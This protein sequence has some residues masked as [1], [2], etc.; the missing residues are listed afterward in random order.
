MPLVYLFVLKYKC[1]H[2][3]LKYI[4]LLKYLGDS[5]KE[6]TN[7]REKRDLVD[8]INVTNDTLAESVQFVQETPTEAEAA[9]KQDVMTTKLV[10]N[11]HYL[12]TDDE[13]FDNEDGDDSENI[14]ESITE[15]HSENSN[16]NQ[17]P[18]VEKPGT[19][20]IKP[21]LKLYNA[22]ILINK[23]SLNLQ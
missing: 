3:C 16:D 21:S 15:F 19:L 5:S 17:T 22:M 8:L 13:K 6:Y 12:D 4:F 7:V 2:T 9:K 18:L 1:T 10:N 23:F 14:A 11:D 20:K